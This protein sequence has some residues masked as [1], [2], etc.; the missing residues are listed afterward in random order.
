MAKF[1][2]EIPLAGSVDIFYIEAETEEEAIK[3]AWELLNTKEVDDVGTIS[4][5]LME[6]VQ[7]GNVCSAPL[8]KQKATKQ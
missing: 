7:E 6:T 4:Y 1:D 3:K 8:W 5:E 2:V